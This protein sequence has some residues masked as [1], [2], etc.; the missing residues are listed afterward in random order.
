MK[1]ETYTLPA[2]FIFG[3][4]TASLQIEGG[5]TNN[6]WYRWSL[7]EGNKKDGTT[8]LTAC[9]HWNR[10]DEDIALIKN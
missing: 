3:A 2:D 10:V 1:P 4:A 6:S 8:P 9:D 7:R 5:D